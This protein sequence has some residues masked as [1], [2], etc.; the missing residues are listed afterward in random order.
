MS[1]TTQRVQTATHLPV[2]HV[3]SQPPLIQP[4]VAPA[5]RRSQAEAHSQ[6][7]DVFLPCQRWFPGSWERLYSVLVCDRIV[8]DR[9]GEDRETWSSWCWCGCNPDRRAIAI[10]SGTTV[11]GAA[12]STAAV[13]FGNWTLT[14]EQQRGHAAQSES[15]M[16]KKKKQQAPDEAKSWSRSQ[17]HYKHL[18]EQE[19]KGPAV[20]APTYNTSWS[21]CWDEAG[22]LCGPTW[23]YVSALAGA[24]PQRAPL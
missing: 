23:S 1:V 16:C 10:F 22:I 9:R 6:L 14:A 5:S 21:V 2:S 24:L 19:S 3:T 17:Q 11:G 18:R 13:L 7:Q 4:S 12:Q 15:D 8:R 20:I